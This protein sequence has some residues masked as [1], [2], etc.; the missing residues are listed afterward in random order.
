MDGW[1][2]SGGRDLLSVGGAGGRSIGGGNPDD[3]GFISLKELIGGGSWGIG[4]GGLSSTG[5]S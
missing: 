1:G 4:G 2:G 3:L 5:K